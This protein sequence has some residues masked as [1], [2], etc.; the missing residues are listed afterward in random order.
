MFVSE[1]GVDGVVTVIVTVTLSSRA[2]APIVQ[3]TIPES[4][5]QPGLALS[6][7]TPEGRVSVTVTPVAASGP[8]FETNSV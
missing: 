7:V 2:T 1:P 4:W 8:R 3:V 5:E 6:K